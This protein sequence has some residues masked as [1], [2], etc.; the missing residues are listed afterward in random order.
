M[1]VVLVMF[2]ATMPGH[3]AVTP[4]LL[5]AASARK[6]SEKPSTAFFVEQYAVMVGRGAIAAPE[7]MFTM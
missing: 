4:T 6:A 5:S 2:V 1:R 7:E 3:I